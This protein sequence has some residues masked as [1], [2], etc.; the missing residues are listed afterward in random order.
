M[1]LARSHLGIE[2]REHRSNHRAWAAL[3]RTKA[4]LRNGQVPPECTGAARTTK[5][6]TNQA[7]T[8]VSFSK[9]AAA[10]ESRRRVGTD[11]YPSPARNSKRSS[12]HEN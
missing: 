3:C 2:G 12:P 7:H 5:A 11:G 10:C 1:A 8:T 6:P 9:I 4:A